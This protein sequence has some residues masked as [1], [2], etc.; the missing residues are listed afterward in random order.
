MVLLTHYHS[1]ASFTFGCGI[2]PDIQ[3][4]GGHTFRPPS[5]S[6]YCVCDIANGNGGLEEM[7]GNQ[8]VRL[9]EMYSKKMMVRLKRDL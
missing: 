1:L 8:Q 4:D 6:G 3:T 7:F 5:L 2:T 9:M